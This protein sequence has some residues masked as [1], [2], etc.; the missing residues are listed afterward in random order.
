MTT[1]FMIKCNILLKIYVSRLSIMYL[2][3]VSDDLYQKISQK[4]KFMFLFI[5]YSPPPQIY[6]T[7]AGKDVQE[8]Q[9]VHKCWPLFISFL[10][11]LLF[12]SRTIYDLVA[13]KV[14]DAK[15]FGFRWTFATDMVSEWLL[16]Y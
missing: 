4:V 14:E 8:A 1:M 16:E 11:I 13:V 9:G 2:I 10:L 3:V 7:R 12:T 15:R 6:T 5:P